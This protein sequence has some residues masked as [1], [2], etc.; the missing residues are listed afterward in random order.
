[1]AGRTRGGARAP[2]AAR[3]SGGLAGAQTS[4]TLRVFSVASGRPRYRLDLAH[5]AGA[6][7]LLALGFGFAAYSSG[8][9]LSCCGSA[10]DATVC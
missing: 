4:S 10:T 1:M 2:E 9:E 3:L 7:R 8:I 6:P 5:A